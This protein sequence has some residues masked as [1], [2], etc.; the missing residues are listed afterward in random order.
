[1]K[2][3]FYDFVRNLRGRTWKQEEAI[4]LHALIDYGTVKETK[5]TMNTVTHIIVGTMQVTVPNPYYSV[6]N[7]GIEPRTIEEIKQSTTHFYSEKEFKNF[8]SK[9]PGMLNNNPSYSFYKVEQLFPKITTTVT[10]DV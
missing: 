7:S 8:L 6:N 5:N 10:I 3:Y 1:M 2:S 9:N 4:V